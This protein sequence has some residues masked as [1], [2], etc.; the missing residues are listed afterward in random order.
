MVISENIPPNIVKKPWLYKNKDD[1]SLVIKV[2][3]IAGPEPVIIWSR[4]GKQ[5]N[6]TA[7]STVSSP[8][9]SH[10]NHSFTLE[11]VRGNSY[12][13]S[14][15]IRSP[16]SRYDTGSY[17]IRATNPHGSAQSQ[18]ELNFVRPEGNL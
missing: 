17:T 18:I 8:S 11:R 12:I 4:D 10:Q 16:D 7:S 15:V 1:G 6:E 13:A 2:E 3:I 9:T 14:L 5:L